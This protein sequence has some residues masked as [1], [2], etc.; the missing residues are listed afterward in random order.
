MQYDQHMDTE[1]QLMLVFSIKLLDF[2]ELLS[3]D[4]FSQQIGF[5]SKQEVDVTQLLS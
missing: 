4:F 5:T 3:Y 1:K 2:S